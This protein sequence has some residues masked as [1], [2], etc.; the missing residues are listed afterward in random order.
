MDP[1]V[2]AAGKRSERLGSS[3]AL[4]PPR[5]AFLQEFLR[6]PMELGTCFTSSPALSRII[7]K[8]L[9]LETARCVVE[10][11]PGT[12]PVTQ[13]ILDRIGPGCRLFVIER[14]QGLADVLRGRWPNLSVHL[15]D[16]ANIRAICEKEGFGPGSIDAVVCSIPLLLL[17]PAAQGA[18]VHDVAA[19]LRPGG[20]FTALTYR[21]EA[22][23][24][25]M[26]KF[27]RLLEREFAVVHPP[28]AVLA[29]VPPAFVYR[30]ER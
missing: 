16:A 13:R 8:D 11:G 14:N 28:R 29:N 21:A 27:R 5:W 24:P 20:G 4:K 10:L 9:G 2:V 22:L 7:V 15:D 12:G 18:I 1:K 25:G 26:K 30:C 17:S 19:V 6:S 3:R 23:V